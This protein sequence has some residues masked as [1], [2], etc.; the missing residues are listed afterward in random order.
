MGG[1]LFPSSQQKQ[2]GLILVSEPAERLKL[3]LLLS[4]Y[5]GGPGNSGLYNIYRCSHANN[6]IAK[7]LKCVIFS[8]LQ[9]V[10]TN[11]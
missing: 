2:S 7:E 1:N 10:S 8:S 5:L 9:C 4:Y 11:Q 3:N 6:G